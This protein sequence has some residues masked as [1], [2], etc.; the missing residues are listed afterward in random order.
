[1]QAMNLIFRHV[2]VSQASGTSN[3]MSCD[4]LLA[5]QCTPG[6][7]NDASDSKV[8]TLGIM[9]I[10]LT[11][12]HYHLQIDTIDPVSGMTVR[13]GGRGADLAGVAK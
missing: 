12:S 6:I 7:I 1:M 10:K 13:E 11:K 4:P 9:A 8:L 2:W 5:G 3:Q